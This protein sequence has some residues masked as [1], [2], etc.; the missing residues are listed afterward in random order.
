[1]ASLEKTL[2]LEKSA[3]SVVSAVPGV[4][5]T[6]DD[7]EVFKKPEPPGQKGGKKTDKSKK[8]SSNAFLCGA[9]TIQSESPIL[10]RS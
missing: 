3:A 9:D 10:L 7:A 5:A 4:P 2:R 6:K 8:V 1:M